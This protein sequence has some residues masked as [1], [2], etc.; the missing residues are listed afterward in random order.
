MLRVFF[1][2]VIFKQCVAGIF[3][4]FVQYAFSECD[5]FNICCS[6][7]VKLAHGN[8]NTSD[9]IHGSHGH[10]VDTTDIMQIFLNQTSE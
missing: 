10:T 2:H 7:S 1:A 4:V 8:S 5:L 6:T 3:N 9:L